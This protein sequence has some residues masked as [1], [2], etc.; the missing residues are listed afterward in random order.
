MTETHSAKML[1]APAYTTEGQPFHSDPGDVVSLF[2]L[3]VAPEGG[4]SKVASSWRV[5]N[6]LAET[7]PDLVKTLSEP[8]P[9]EMY[10]Y[11]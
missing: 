1:G 4:A 5:Y 11:F 7:R 3:E 2:A 9:L 6:E 10:A 8:F